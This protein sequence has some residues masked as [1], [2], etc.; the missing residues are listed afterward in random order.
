MHRKAPFQWLGKR[1]LW[2]VIR[3]VGRESAVSGWVATIHKFESVAVPW[4]P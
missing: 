3:C 4:P 1:R 2:L